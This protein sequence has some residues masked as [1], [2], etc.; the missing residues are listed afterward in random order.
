M[1]I[2]RI[3]VVGAGT[4]GAQIAAQSALHGLDVVLVDSDEGQLAEAERSNRRLLERRADKG[5]MTKEEV[6][7]GLGRIRAS[8][9][10]EEIATCQLVIE[11]VFEDMAVKR[12]VFAEL[13]EICA[14]DAILAT[15]SSTFPISRLYDDLPYPDRACNLHFFHP[16]L[17]MRLVEIMR[18]PETSD[19]TVAALIAFADRIERE[20]VLIEREISGLIVNR[21]LAAIKREALW[22]ASEGYAEP[23]DIDRAVKMGLN[24]PMGPFELTDFSGLDVFYRIMRQRYEESGDEAWKPPRLLEKKVQA[25]ELGR[26]TGKGFYSY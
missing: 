5:T 20:A 4:M 7:S 19:E 10:L 22:L 16:V 2:K 15:N 13:A 11:A 6:V 14:P 23:E 18:G 8:R 1:E 3:G 24:H 25:G 12:A 26:K 21:I 17:A 9:D